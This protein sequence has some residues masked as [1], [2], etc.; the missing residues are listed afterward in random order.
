MNK[1]GQVII[2]GIMM[3][4]IGLILAVILSQPIRELIDISRGADSMDCD[5]TSI[6]TGTRMTCIVFDIFL[7][8]FVATIIFLSGSYLFYKKTTS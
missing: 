6:S 1:S 3:M 2:L 4:I 5:N 7:P 8:Y